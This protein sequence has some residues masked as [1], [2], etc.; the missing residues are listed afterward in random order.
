[1]NEKSQKKV[2]PGQSETLSL[3]KKQFF[4]TKM[5]PFQKNKNYCLNESDCHYAHSIDELKPMPDLRNTK[6]CDYI[7]KKMPCKDVNCKFAHDTETLKPSVHL[8]T[9]KSTICSFWGKGKCFNGN[10]CR[11]A[12]GTNDIKANENMNI[13]EN[14]K[15][16]HK[17]NKDSI[18]D[19][20][21][22]T[23]S[24]YSFNTYDYS[25]NCSLETTNISPSF[26]KSRELFVL[27]ENNINDDKLGDN[28]LSIFDSNKEIIGNINENTDLNISKMDYPFCENTNNCSINNSDNIK[29]VINKIENMALSTFIE[30][31]DKYTKVI[32]YLMNENN[33]LKESIK[34]EQKHMINEED[35]ISQIQKQIYKANISRAY[36]KDNGDNIANISRAYTKD[37]GDNIANI[38]R[39]YTKDNGDNIVTISGKSNN[40]SN[41]MFIEDGL[42]K[43]LYFDEP[44]SNSQ[45]SNENKDVN[46]GILNSEDFI[47]SDDNFTNI[48]K[49]IDDLLISQNVGSFSNVKNN[50]NSL[51]SKDIFLIKNSNNVNTSIECENL[52]CNLRLFDS[53]KNIYQNFIASNMI[54][55]N[56]GL[57]RDINEKVEIVENPFDENIENI[58]NII[59]T[60]QK[61]TE[62]TKEKAKEKAK[63]KTKEKTKESYYNEHIS[64]EQCKGASRP[65]DITNDEFSYLNS[66]NSGNNSYCN[67]SNSSSYNYINNPDYNSSPN[68]SNNNIRMNEIDEIPHWFKGF[69]QID[70]Q[71]NETLNMKQN[72]LYSKKMKNE[73]FVKN[74]NIE[75]WKER[76]IHQNGNEM[77]E[78]INSN[79]N[80]NNNNNLIVGNELN[81]YF[82]QSKNN[83]RFINKGDFKEK[84]AKLNLRE[85]VD[86]KYDNDNLYKLLE[87]SHDKSN[88]INKIKK[89]I[90][91][92]LKNNE[93]SNFTNKLKYNNSNN[94]NV[95]N[96]VNCNG[97]SINNLGKKNT[98]LN[99]YVNM[100]NLNTI[101]SNALNDIS[102]NNIYNNKNSIS[103]SKMSSYFN[104]NHHH[105]HNHHNNNNHNN[106]N[107][108]NNHNNN[109]KSYDTNEYNCNYLSSDFMKYKKEN[110]VE[111]NIWNNSSNLN[112]FIYPTTPTTSTTD[113]VSDNNNNDVFNISKSVN[114]RSLN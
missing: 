57:I 68:Y 7:K 93:N 88:I 18:S 59:N 22:G 4:K 30:N 10:K 20:T 14:N 78:E 95:Q 8:A 105:H 61:E 31:N 104:N 56:K 6:L 89:L 101:Y 97:N 107:N 23:D 34:K 46:N 100:K 53:E 51:E 9:Y 37:N 99:D 24:T 111:K 81:K 63:E 102:T 77:P 103:N 11:F 83:N 47:K 28:K 49:T 69:S 84:S 72:K 1:M 90:S 67:I 17:K 74:P 114:L 48:M 43:Y 2:A 26:D 15:H 108:N 55:S 42:K 35:H 25:V 41:S 38:S 92:E 27:K 40:S 87:F 54:N 21:K 39:A 60:C 80:N 70:V 13:L 52:P 82:F 12:H 96:M 50:C 58:E 73:E 106:N 110:N 71:N 19:I 86:V 64:Y 32:K 75:Y 85:N 44:S 5:C 65:I 91:N 76:M 45:F 66:S 33:I 62:K 36:T 98:L 29:T 79:S 94:Q 113:L 109:N 112:G 3:I 16:N